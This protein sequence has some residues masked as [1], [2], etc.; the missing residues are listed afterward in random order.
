MLNLFSKNWELEK[1]YQILKFSLESE[2]RNNSSIFRLYVTAA[3]KIDC[4]NII[5]YLIKKCFKY[6]INI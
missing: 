1:F 3:F 4:F 2:F 6:F 5:N